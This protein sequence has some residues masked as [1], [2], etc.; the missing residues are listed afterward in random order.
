MAGPKEN[1]EKV[2]ALYRLK[3]KKLHDMLNVTQS[4]DLTSP[5][6]NVDN[7]M[8]MV[9][10]RDTLLNEI[11][12]IEKALAHVG[13]PDKEAARLQ[14]EAKQIAGQI[15]RCDQEQQSV[16][17]A[18]VGS[19]KKNMCDLSKHKN[20]SIHYHADGRFLDISQFDK[21]K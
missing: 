16:V 11:R 15:I 1:D 20:A 21:Q 3:C 7:Y 4:A 19:I 5:R 2:L 10:R 17:Q 12:D 13:P 14:Q 9:E 8:A 18:M 6:E